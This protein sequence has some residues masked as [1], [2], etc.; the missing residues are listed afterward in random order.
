MILAS[1]WTCILCASVLLFASAFCTSSGFPHR[2]LGPGLCSAPC[3][4][5]GSFF[6]ASGFTHCHT[7]ASVFPFTLFWHRDLRFLAESF[8]SL[9]CPNLLACRAIL[10]LL[11]V[12]I[13]PISFSCSA[14]AFF[15]LNNECMLIMNCQCKCGMNEAKCGMNL[16]TG[17]TG[18][19]F[20]IPSS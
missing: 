7:D 17:L 2:F 14:H 6:T 10:K 15:R 3:D 8:G 18:S 16:S 1:V 9:I 11:A 19:W 5:T 20:K 4:G 13:L 12:A